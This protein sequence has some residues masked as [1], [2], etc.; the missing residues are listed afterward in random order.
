MTR[1]QAGTYLGVAP[2]FMT[3][4]RE[5]K[6]PHR[7]IGRNL[8][9]LPEELEEWVEVGEDDYEGAPCRTCEAR[10]AGQRRRRPSS[11][12]GDAPTAA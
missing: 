6:I 10:E 1:E 7:H 4:Y 2:K 5:H 3:R 8:R 11:Q 12:P 9:F